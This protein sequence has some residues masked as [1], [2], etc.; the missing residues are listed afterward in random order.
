LTARA[1]PLRIEIP[2]IDMPVFDMPMID[3]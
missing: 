2:M 3:H 1:D